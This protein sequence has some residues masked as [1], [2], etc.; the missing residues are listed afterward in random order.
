[1]TI[2]GLIATSLTRANLAHSTSD[3]EKPVSPPVGEAKAEL[4]PPGKKPAEPAGAREARNLPTAKP[5]KRPD[6]AFPSHA[7]KMEMFR[8]SHR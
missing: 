4:K 6:G 2:A 8:K 5:A 7:R 1:M 3:A